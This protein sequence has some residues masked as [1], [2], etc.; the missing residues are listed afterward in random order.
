MASRED[1]KKLYGYQWQKIRKVHLTNNPL[2]RF[3]QEDG[4]ITPAEVVDHIV[5]HDGDLSL[6]YDPTNLQ[7]LCKEHHDSY[8]QRIE[9]SG[10][11]TATDINGNPLRKMKHWIR[12]GGSTLKLK[13]TKGGA[14]L[15]SLISGTK[16]L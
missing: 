13:R 14:N 8:K 7:S 11:D 3:C 5:K 6:F 2:C 9:S 10:K 12:G 15:F 4:R 16:K 1:K